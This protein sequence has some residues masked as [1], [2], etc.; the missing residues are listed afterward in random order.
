M[1]TAERLRHAALTFAARARWSPASTSLCW[2]R[3]ALASAITAHA[4]AIIMHTLADRATQLGLDTAPSAQMRAAAEALNRCWPAWRAVAH[5]WDTVSTS[6]H[7]RAGPT[8]VAAEIGD[9]ALRTGRLAYNHP[10]WTPAFR[11]A[12]DPLLDWEVLT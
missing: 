12:S 10:D 5:H 2:R 7:R 3:D 8:P 6:M 1:V 11:R 4:G 9:L